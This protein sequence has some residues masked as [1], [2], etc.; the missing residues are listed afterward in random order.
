LDQALIGLS[1][2]QASDL[3]LLLNSP[4]WTSLSFNEYSFKI[5]SIVRFEPDVLQKV[6]ELKS[7]QKRVQFLKD[8]LTRSVVH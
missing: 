2:G 3:K 6:L 7:A 5:F 4:E 8:I 1:Q